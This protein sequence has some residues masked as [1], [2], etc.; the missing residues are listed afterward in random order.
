MRYQVIEGPD[1]E[2]MTIRLP[3]AVG[4][5]NWKEFKRT[6]RSLPRETRYLMDLSRVERLDTSGFAMLLQF[7][8]W[9]GEEQA[10]ITLMGATGEVR[11]LLDFVDCS[12][13]FKQL[14]N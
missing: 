11:Q 7:R 6:L 3:R 14:E 1:Q 13:W 12:R 2:S 9:M 4:L 8:D 10:D 5:E